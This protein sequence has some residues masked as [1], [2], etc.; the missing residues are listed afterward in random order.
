MSDKDGKRP[1]P[2]SPFGK[3]EE[4]MRKLVS[5]PA[6]EVDAKERAYRRKKVRKKRRSA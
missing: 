6:E 2:G 5:V 4:L 1:A 3:F